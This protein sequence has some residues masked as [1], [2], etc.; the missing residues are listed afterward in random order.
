MLILKPDEGRVAMQ[1]CYHDYSSDCNLRSSAYKVYNEKTDHAES[2]SF[3]FL[4]WVCF[5]FILNSYTSIA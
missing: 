1:I 5:N 4:H 3:Y 2:N